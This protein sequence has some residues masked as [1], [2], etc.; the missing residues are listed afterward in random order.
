MK[1]FIGTI[2]RFTFVMLL[3]CISLAGHAQKISEK[4]A[5]VIASELADKYLKEFLETYEGKELM[6]FLKSQDKKIKLQS[7]YYNQT[8]LDNNE[9]GHLVVAFVYVKPLNLV[10]FPERFCV[11][12][13][14]DGSNA[15]MVTDGSCQ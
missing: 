9:D 15:T 5:Q 11:I 6:G 1:T 4:E 14:G 12:M 2:G 13:E 7:K 3:A 8:V 10:K